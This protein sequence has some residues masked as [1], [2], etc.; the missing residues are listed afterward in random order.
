MR[1]GGR[2]GTG[3]AA[4]NLT[5]FSPKV[6]DGRGLICRPLAKQEAGRAARAADIQDRRGMRLRMPPNEK[7][8]HR[9]VPIGQGAAGNV[10]DRQPPTGN[11]SRRAGGW[12]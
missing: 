8:P 11:A 5:S 1:C 3:Q 7:R 2:P 9:L 10:M 12:A 6:I 4:R